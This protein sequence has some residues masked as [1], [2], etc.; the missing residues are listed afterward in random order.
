MKRKL[1]EELVR[2]CTEIITSKETEDYSKLYNSAKELYE[3]LAVLKYI[4]EKLSDIEIDVSKNVL[5]A[6]F[7]MMANAVISENR[8]VPEN[9]PH[10]EDIITPGI[11][12]IKHMVSE[13]PTS[14]EVEKI[15]AEFVAKK[16]LLKSD[17][18]FLNPEADQENT[19][20]IKTK[21]INDILT[22]KELSVGLNDRL[23]FVKHLFDGNKEYFDKAITQLNEIDS[24]ERSLAFVENLVKP[25]FDNWTGQQ[26]YEKRFIDLIKRRFA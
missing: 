8:T 22:G 25:E 15:F 17:K 2:L 13:M 12:T 19:K 1:K 26:E 7:E 14:E 3:K 10:E 24:E 6:K 11:D 21:S 5:A 16:D 9:N 20:N 18:D 4:E 23:A